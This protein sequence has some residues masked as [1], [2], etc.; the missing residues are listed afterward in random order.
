MFV[1]AVVPAYNEEERVGNTV[2]ALKKIPSLGEI[3]V[4]DDG[5]TDRT[6]VEAWKAGAV[7]CRRSSNGGKSQSLREGA[8]LAKGEILA[9][10]DAD[11]QET[12]LEF[13]WLI[14]SVINDEADMVI[15]SLKTKRRAGL[16]LTRS[17]AYWTIFIYTGRK[18]SAPL[19][20]QRVLK[21]ALWESLCFPAEGYAAEVALTV[22][23][24]RRGFRVKEIPLQMS[25][26]YYGNDLHSFLH[27]GQQF[28][29]LLKLIVANS[30]TA[31]AGGR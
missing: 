24:L 12:A 26:R 25:H 3:I 13:K 8:C 5:S 22:E 17:L 19:S 6:A 7:I 15:A 2:R 1:S 28:Y 11:L 23:S 30:R 27:R 4:V 21:R 9:F 10:V 18:M 14:D 29:D 16:G 20:G 31:G